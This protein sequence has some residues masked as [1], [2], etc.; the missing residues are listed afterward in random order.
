[1]GE[2]HGGGDEGGGGVNKSPRSLRPGA[3]ESLSFLI[4]E[5]KSRMAEIHGAR[6][7]EETQGEE[8]RPLEGSG[9]NE[10]GGE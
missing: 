2:K 10:R 1:V 9:Q 4:G 6:A 7:A 8:T 3:N 5:E